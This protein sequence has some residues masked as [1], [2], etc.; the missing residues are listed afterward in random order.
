M[1]SIGQTEV[2]SMAP[3]IHPADMARKGLFF[4]VWVV[5]VMMASK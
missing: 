3:A 5:V 2:A 1:Y 4:F